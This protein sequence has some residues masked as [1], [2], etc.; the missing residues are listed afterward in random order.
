MSPCFS[1]P[2]CFGVHDVFRYLAPRNLPS[3]G[4]FPF[5][6]TLLCDTDSK[7]KDTPYGPRDLL[8]RK[9]ID[10]T[11]F[12]DSEIPKKSS[13][14]EKDSN[15]S[16]Q[17]T[18]DSERS[19][20]S[21]ATLPPR[22][23]FDVEGMGTEI[24][25]GS[26]V[27]THILDLEKMS[28]DPDNQQRVF[29][30]LAQ[31]LSFFSQVQQRREVWQ[32]LSSFPDVLQNNTSLSGLFGVLQKANR[33]LLVAQKVYPRVQ[34][35]EGFS[36]LRKS[37]KH[38]LNTLDFPA[39][40]DNSTHAWSDDDEQTLSPSSLAAQLLILENFED[41]ILNISSN[42]PY[43]PYLECIRNMTDN[44]ARGSSDNLR[45][46]QSTIRFRKPF[47]QN[48]SYEDDFLSFPEVLKSKLSQLR[49]LTELLCE[50]ETFSSLEKSCQP[51]NLSFNRMCEDH[52]FHVQ[53]IEA[54][55]L[56]VDLATGLLYHDNVISAK[57]RDLL[58]G[59][60]SK[61]NLNMD[62]LLEQALQMNYLENI[63]RLIPTVEAMLHV[64]TSV[65]ASEQPGQLIEMFK[66]IDELKEELKAIGMSN[67]SINK[68]L[69]I[70][71]PDNRA[72]IISR[73]FWLHS[74]DANV[75]NPKLEDAMK[76]F[77]K[78]P[79]PERSHQSYLIGLTLLHYLD[80]YNFT[81]K[82]SC[83]GQFPFFFLGKYPILSQ[84]FMVCTYAPPG[85][86][87]YLGPWLPCGVFP[88]ERS[89]ASGKDDGAFHK[90]E[91]DSQPVSFRRTSTAGQNEIPETNASA[92]NCSI[93]TGHVQKHQDE[94]SSGIFQYHLPSALF[95]RDYH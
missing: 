29:Q 10:E 35:D 78:L 87:M 69:A 63:T 4:F 2:A 45:L 89:K 81:Y 46:L 92:Q 9:G 44:L 20:T 37:V 15:L 88:K 55:E 62:W 26:Q 33:V 61:I 94:H 54:A 80:I 83:H 1:G 52:A 22:P 11:L 91:K 6:Q 72:E 7:C 25:N 73:V 8:R 59:D 17:S 60:P 68:M 56:G 5:L 67:T 38:L 65:D 43:F 36:T 74:C 66:N 70:P 32:L 64:N 58:T 90:A 47:P 40:G 41:A 79:L 77:C 42:S 3:A 57:L 14:P 31:A 86:I 27:L 50:S 48:S 76:E 30:G 13:K 19:H 71:I 18:H 85:I 53:L 82:A 75:T 23:S 28:S 24:F 95:A 49:N 21:L 51:P 16:L 12:K 93:N 39:Q 84:G 34:T